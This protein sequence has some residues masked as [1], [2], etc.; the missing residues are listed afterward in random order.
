MSCIVVRVFCLMGRTVVEVFVCTV[1]D[2][3]M[4][5]TVLGPF[6]PPNLFSVAARWNGHSWSG[7]GCVEGTVGRSRGSDKL[8]G[9]QQHSVV[10]RRS[11]S[12]DKNLVCICR[13]STDF[14]PYACLLGQRSSGTRVFVYRY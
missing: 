5:S 2:L 1:Q 8:F 3:G 4:A 6:F 13:L 10:R 14:G 9:I 11:G 12:I 7:R